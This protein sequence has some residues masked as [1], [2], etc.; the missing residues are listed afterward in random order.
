MA[1]VRVNRFGALF[2]RLIEML[3]GKVRYHPIL[4]QVDSPKNNEMVIG[5][6]HGVIRAMLALSL[7]LSRSR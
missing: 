5:P 7:P 2:A 6:V 3:A 1:A 4:G